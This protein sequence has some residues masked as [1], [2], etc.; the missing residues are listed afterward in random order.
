MFSKDF[1]EKIIKTVGLTCLGFFV[2]LYIFIM[3]SYLFFYNSIHTFCCGFGMFVLAFLFVVVFI[4]KNKN[5][6]KVLLDGIYKFFGF[7]LLIF[8]L[9]VILNYFFVIS[10]AFGEIYEFRYVDFLAFFLA[11]FMPVFILLFIKFKYK[12]KFIT[13]T[14][15]L[16]FLILLIF[17]LYNFYTFGR[18]EV[19]GVSESVNRDYNNINVDEYLPFDVNSKIARLNKKAS[20]KLDGKLPKI[21]GAAAVFPLYSSFV[22]AIYPESV[23]LGDDIFSYDNTVLGYLK[24]ADRDIDVFFGAYPSEEQIEY[25][26]N[27]GVEFEYTPIGKEGFVFFVNKE[28]PVDN[29]TI[30]QLQDIYS[31]KITNWKKVGGNFIRIIPFQRNEGS[32]SQS[33]LK[34]FMGDKKLMNP[35]KNITNDFMMGIIENIANYNNYKNAI[36]FSF[37][38][39]TE[40]MVKNNN[41]KLLS[42]DGEMPNLENNSNDK[43][44]INTKLYAVTR[45]G[46]HTSNVDKLLE[47]ILSKEGQELVYKTGYAKIS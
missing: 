6:I 3:F 44:P 15:V 31:G 24:L 33:M 16:D 35:P 41:V 9:I 19:Y 46:E 18:L 29:L 11:L 13:F 32:G 4:K 40:D 27:N 38:Y 43:Y 28:N 36:G 45:K 17:C 23:K 20:I 37:R 7:I 26:K 14:L 39:Y 22:N 21:D 2:S 10:H 25:A 1:F 42:I 8:L 47:W 12:K 34:R 5:I 30:K